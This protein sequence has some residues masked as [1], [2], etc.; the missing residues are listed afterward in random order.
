MCKL[1]DIEL[2]IA[3]FGEV[4]SIWCAAYVHTC[5]CNCSIC[6]VV[7][8]VAEFLLQNVFSLTILCV[9]SFYLGRCNICWHWMK[10]RS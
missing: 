1:S 3:N 8:T 5:I 6:E 9:Q 4:S 10:I 7:E 2:E